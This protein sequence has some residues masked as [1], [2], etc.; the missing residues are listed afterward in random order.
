MIGQ[1]SMQYFIAQPPKINSLFEL[2]YFPSIWTQRCNYGAL[3]FPLGFV[4]HSNPSGKTWSVTYNL[5]TSKPLVRAMSASIV[6]KTTLQP[7]N[8][9]CSTALLC[10]LTGVPPKKISFFWL[11]HVHRE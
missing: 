10:R 9:F 2:K 1:F 8:H 11:I 6:H 4:A 3:C 7:Y 5:W